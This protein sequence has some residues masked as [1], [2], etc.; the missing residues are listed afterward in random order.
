MGFE[1]RKKPESR[2]LLGARCDRHNTRAPQFVLDVLSGPSEWWRMATTKTTSPTILKKPEGIIEW[3]GSEPIKTTRDN[4]INTLRAC[5]FIG[6]SV[7]VFANG[8]WTKS[9]DIDRPK[10]LN[11]Q[12]AL[13]AQE[14]L[15]HRIHFELKRFLPDGTTIEF[16]GPDKAPWDGG[17]MMEI[18]DGWTL[19][20]TIEHDHGYRGA[21]KWHAFNPEGDPLVENGTEIDAVAELVASIANYHVR[22]NWNP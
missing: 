15:L 8:K 11:D 5:R 22:N 7:K 9:E 20:P 4:A 1:A 19:G 14:Q 13:I 2:R 21:I 3:P 6:E 12:Q 16:I 18:G 10:G 17:W